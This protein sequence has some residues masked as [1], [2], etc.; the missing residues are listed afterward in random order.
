M[1]GVVGSNPIA[2]TN[3]IKELADFV[4]IENVLCPKYVLNRLQDSR[5]RAPIQALLCDLD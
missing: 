4:G 1:V 5:A 3:E 2:P